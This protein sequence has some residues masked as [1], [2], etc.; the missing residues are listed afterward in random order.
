[1]MNNNIIKI[2][3]KQF[4]FPLQTCFDDFVCG[5]LLISSSPKYAMRG[6]KVLFIHFTCI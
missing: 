2:I 1:M 5:L 3:S 6:L 4:H